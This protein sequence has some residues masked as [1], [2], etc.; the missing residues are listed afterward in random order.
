MKT[1]FKTGWVLSICL[2]ALAC[3]DSEK[4]STITCTLGSSAIQ[5]P[6]QVAVK[7][8]NVSLTFTENG[9]ATLSCMGLPPAPESQPS[10]DAGGKIVTTSAN[11]KAMKKSDKPDKVEISLSWDCS[12]CT[13]PPA[14]GGEALKDIA[15]PPPA[16]ATVVDGTKTMEGE[17]TL[18]VDDK[19]DCTLEQT[20]NVQVG[21]T[22]PGGPT[23]GN[24]SCETG[25]DA[26]NCP[27]DCTGST[28]PPPPPAPPG[29][30][31]ENCSNG[32]DDDADGLVDANDTDCGAAGAGGGGN[33]SRPVARW[34]GPGQAQ[35]VTEEAAPHFSASDRV[36]DIFLT[37]KTS[38]AQEAGMGS[39]PGFGCYYV[40]LC[41]QNSREGCI[42]ALKYTMWR[43]RPYFWTYA[44][45]Q[46]SGNS[47]SLS[48]LT[49]Q[50]GV[51]NL[52]AENVRRYRLYIRASGVQR[53]DNPDQRNTHCRAYWEDECGN[54]KCVEQTTGPELDD[55]W[56]VASYQVMV[57]L[58]N[59]REVNFPE[60]DN[61]QK[62]GI[63]WWIG[64]VGG[65]IKEL[66]YSF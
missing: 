47:R 10:V 64:K 28:P 40:D 12:Q 62:G 26:T 32:I 15:P 38:N 16:R 14:N 25:E 65:V 3:S 63:G 2:L 31:A 7:A 9:T 13:C 51:A 1:A 22:A 11:M 59:G 42:K 57:K 29:P 8:E 34:V 21:T 53:Q 27:A 54:K 18:S 48:S 6:T 56:H 33:N 17:P 50:F 36:S 58:T 55:P 45:A 20:I 41:P 52:S 66:F 39:A 23:C 4:K 49:C 35:V 5:A 46:C 60:R 44:G 19:G 30:T 61:Y 43:D 37:L 24:G